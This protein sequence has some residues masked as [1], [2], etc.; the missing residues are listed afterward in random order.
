MKKRDKI[1]QYNKKAL[2]IKI[3]A[4]KRKLE[5]KIHQRPSERQKSNIAKLDDEKKKLER[6]EYYEQLEEQIS[7]LEKDIKRVEKQIDDLSFEYEDRKNEMNKRNLSKFYTN[8][9]SFAFVRFTD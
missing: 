4:L 5:L 9:S 1:Y 2:T 8:L 7:S 3:E 6:L